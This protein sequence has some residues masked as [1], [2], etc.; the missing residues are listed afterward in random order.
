MKVRSFLVLGAGR[1][2]SALVRTLFDAGHEVVVADRSEAAIQGVMAHATHAVVQDVADEQALA[3][4]GPANFDAVVVAIGESFESAVLAVAA[5]K[6][7]GARRVLAKASG[8]L[9]ARVLARVGADDVIRPEHDTGVRVARQLVTPALL[10]SF[11]LGVGHGV[12]EIV[13][14]ANLCGTL[15]HLRLPNRYRVQVI[16]VA[17]GDALTAAPKADVEILPGD[18]L[19]LIGANAD[20]DRFRD[21]LGG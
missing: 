4:L 6:G 8:D 16:A 21:D 1:F 14:G 15:A 17:R 12:I 2:G 10:E 11:E 18:R 7:L 13:A 19:V 9:T 20:L 5:A 3:R